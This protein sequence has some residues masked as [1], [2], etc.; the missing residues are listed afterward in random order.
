MSDVLG[1]KNNTTLLQD[2]KALLD[3][4]DGVI[5]LELYQCS[6]YIDEEYIY[7]NMDSNLEHLYNQDGNSFSEYFCGAVLEQEG[8][9]LV[10]ID[11]GCGYTGVFLNALKVKYKD[12]HEEFG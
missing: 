3:R 8:L 6:W 1:L 5:K 9:T 4:L 11:D 2:I 10:S 7:W 12:L